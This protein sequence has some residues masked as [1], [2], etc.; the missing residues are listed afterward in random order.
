VDDV[1]IGPNGTVMGSG[2]TLLG[3]VENHGTLAPGESPGTLTIQGDLTQAADGKLVIEIGGNTPGSLYDVL[4][5]T[6]KFTFGGT[7]EIN[8]IGGFTPEAGDVFNFLQFGSFEGS[9]ANIILSTF[10]T[11]QTLHLNFGPNGITAVSAVPLPAAVW[12][13]SSA[14]GG[15]AFARRRA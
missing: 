9:F 1:L 6:G 2:G 10:G 14:L 3:A 8:L 12:L 7:L 5:V 4:N 11:G 13:L 15:L